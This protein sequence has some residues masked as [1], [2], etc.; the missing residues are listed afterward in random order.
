VRFQFTELLESWQGCFLP[1][2]V[3]PRGDSA[4]NDHFFSRA[5][6]GIPRSRISFFRVKVTTFTCLQSVYYNYCKAAKKSGHPGRNLFK[7][8][9]CRRKGVPTIPTSQRTMPSGSGFTRQVPRSARLHSHRGAFCC[10]PSRE[11]RAN[12]QLW[13]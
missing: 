13:Q 4:N 12:Y 5:F 9:A 11:L 6:V 3:A 1:L 8:E 10:N 7:A 2:K